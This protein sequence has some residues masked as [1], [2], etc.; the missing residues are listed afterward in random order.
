LDP[1][2]VAGVNDD[3]VV[4]FAAGVE[5]GEEFA[6]GLVEPSDV[7]VVAGGRFVGGDFGV[8]S[9]QFGGGSVGGMRKEGGVPDQPG[10]LGLA[11]FIE[12]GS[13]GSVTFAAD[14]EADVAVATGISLGHGV[15][16]TGGFLGVALPPFAGLQREVTAGREVADE[17]GLAGEVGDDGFVDGRD[18]GV[19]AG[20]GRVGFG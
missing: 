12:E 1:A 13:D 5:F 6:A 9:E 20:L 15:G 19:F 14:F 16:E 10:L 11:G 17:V 7:G 8:V 18:G 2:V 4:A 3:G